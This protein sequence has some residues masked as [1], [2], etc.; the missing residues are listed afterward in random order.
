[1]VVALKE[2]SLDCHQEWYGNF[3]DP[4]GYLAPLSSWDGTFRVP[5]SGSE[6]L[7]EAF[8]AAKELQIVITNP[9]DND[10]E[11][12]DG[13]IAGCIYL[14]QI[15][16]VWDEQNHPVYDFAFVGNGAPIISDLNSGGGRE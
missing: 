11:E 16:L 3:D 8:F 1:M 10:E 13:L 7:Y 15:N 9:D 12:S 5:Q 6:S 14:T 2:W 4:D